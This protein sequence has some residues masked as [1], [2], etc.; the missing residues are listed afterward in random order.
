MNIIYIR[1]SIV[2]YQLNLFYPECQR[3]IGF[4]LCAKLRSDD[5]QS[6]RAPW[7]KFWPSSTQSCSISQHSRLAG[8]QHL[9]LRMESFPSRRFRRLADRQRLIRFSHPQDNA[10][11]PLPRL[12][13]G[14]GP[15]S[16]GPPWSTRGRAGCHWTEQLTITS[17]CINTRTVSAL[18]PG[19]G[20][21]PR[22]WQ[23]G[24]AAGFCHVLSTSNADCVCH[25]EERI[26]GS[27]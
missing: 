14:I 12:S 26:L 7:Q 11:L 6:S 16:S 5:A 27:S 20:S 4:F 21:T 23:H 13:G 15:L 18:I 25:V 3:S 2:P 10:A 8:M 9:S 22:S 1:F 19:P 24:P 17:S